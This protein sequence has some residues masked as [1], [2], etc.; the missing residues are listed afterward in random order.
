MPGSEEE[1]CPRCGCAF[2]CM[3]GNI[4]ACQCSTVKL[5]TEQRRHLSERYDGC[6]C[7]A[8]LAEEQAGMRETR[9]VRR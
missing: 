7:A 1:R 6:L 4:A 8:C 5:D 9:G 3:A 2:T